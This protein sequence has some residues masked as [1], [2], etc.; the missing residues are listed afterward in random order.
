MERNEQPTLKNCCCK[1]KAAFAN[2]YCIFTVL[3]NF[4]E[5]CFYIRQK[6]DFVCRSLEDGARAG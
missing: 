2:L 5:L 3:F 1:R 6:Y 4:V